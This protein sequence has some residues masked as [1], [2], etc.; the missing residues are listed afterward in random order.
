MFSD[1]AIYTYPLSRYSTK[2]LLKRYELFC[3]QLAIQR[4]TMWDYPSDTPMFS[5]H[6]RQGDF[7]D[8]ALKEL[9]EFLVI[10]RFVD[11]NY[12]IQLETSIFEDVN[13]DI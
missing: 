10:K 8:G 2:A 6:R 11:L 12:L 3:L 13:S 4:Q 9:S 7:F 1:F 5:W